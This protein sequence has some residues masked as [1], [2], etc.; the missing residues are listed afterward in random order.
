MKFRY[1]FDKVNIILFLLALINAYLSFPFF[2]TPYYSMS[3][4]MRRYNM[5]EVEFDFKEG[6]YFIAIRTSTSVNDL[7][8]HNLVLF[9]ALG[10]NKTDGVCPNKFQENFLH[11]DRQDYTSSSCVQAFSQ[12]IHFLSFS[13]LETEKNDKYIGPRERSQ[14]V[15]FFHFHIQTPLNQKVLKANLSLFMYQFNETEGCNNVSDCDGYADYLCSHNPKEDLS[16]PQVIFEN[17][18]QSCIQP[19]DPFKSSLVNTRCALSLVLSTNYHCFTGKLKETGF[20]PLHIHQKIGGDCSFDIFFVIMRALP[21]AL[22]H[23]WSWGN[24][25]FATSFAFYIFTGLY[26][27]R[28]LHLSYLRQYFFNSSTINLKKGEKYRIKL[29]VTGEQFSQRK[30]VFQFTCGKETL[31]S[32]ELN[33]VFTEEDLSGTGQR[34]LIFRCSFQPKQKFKNV[35]YSIQWENIYRKSPEVQVV[36]RRNIPYLLKTRLN[37]VILPFMF[38][39]HLLFCRPR[40][41]ILNY[42][43]YIWLV[44]YLCAVYL[45]FVIVVVY[46][47][48]ALVL[49]PGTPKENKYW[50]TQTELPSI[51]IVFLVLYEF[52]TIIPTFMRILPATRR[53]LETK[54][55]VYTPIYDLRDDAPPDRKKKY[56]Q[57]LKDINAIILTPLNDDEVDSIAQMEVDYV[58]LVEKQEEKKEHQQEDNEL[59]ISTSQT[60]DFELEKSAKPKI[61]TKN[62]QKGN[63]SV[64]EIPEW[65]DPSNGMNEENPLLDKAKG[66]SIENKAIIPRFQP[67]NQKKSHQDLNL[68]QNQNQK[69]NEAQLFDDPLTSFLKND[70]SQEKNISNGNLIQSDKTTSDSETS[71][72]FL[73][74]QKEQNSFIS[75]KT[76][77]SPIEKKEGNQESKINFQIFD[78]N[79]SDDLF[80]IPSIPFDKKNI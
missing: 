10:T 31:F 38:I 71:S 79:D 44:A 29:I 60:S 14:Q 52:S 9:F 47:A 62:E 72:D 66:Q 40:K 26:F 45:S 73:E 7:K 50:G 78:E 37:I 58:H 39:Y 4:P 59:E 75:K 30:G 12:D 46:F 63:F 33:A 42:R 36:I 77:N 2:L 25:L 43:H 21:F 74:N 3:G 64:Y 53:I 17:Q 22:E 32:F 8:D 20:D 69:D 19:S 80:E 18:T 65:V 27:A 15:I 56:Q 54:P 51:P 70:I 49:S 34:T 24:I 6:D 16:E 28:R 76:S 5:K 35:K 57:A 55:F 67:Q 68:N 61:K 48:E 41:K 23:I 1:L 13:P 11:T